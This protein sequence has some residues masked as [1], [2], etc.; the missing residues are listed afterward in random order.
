MTR[1]IVLAV[2]GLAGAGLAAAH[3]FWLVPVGDEIEGRTGSAF[4][5]STNAVSPARLAEAVAVSKAERRSLEVLGQRDAALVLRADRALP[6]ALWAAVTLHPRRIDLSAEEFNDYLRHDGLPQI[7]ALRQARGEL[8]RPAVERYQKF[9][10]A[11]IRRP[12]AGSVALEPVGHRIELVPLDDPA[13]LTPGDTL[14]VEVRFEGTPLAGLTVHAGYEGQPGGAHA[15]THL[16][17]TAGRVRVPLTAA[18]L[19]YVRTIHMREATDPP[20][21][22]ESFWATLTFAAR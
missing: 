14:R 8:D 21:Q 9:A 13:T 3:D 15:Q 19:W 18:G 11:L 4:P 10:K 6:G 16:S 2:L 20:Y 17:D 7:H 5:I 1:A 22:W 12:G